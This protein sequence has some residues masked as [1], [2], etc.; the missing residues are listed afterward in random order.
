MQYFNAI[1]LFTIISSITLL[2]ITACQSSSSSSA[3]Y[4]PS[5]ITDGVDM[6]QY[7]IDKRNCLLEIQRSYANIESTNQIRFRECL[8]GKGYKLMS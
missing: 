8:I 7:E 3:T 2:L 6:K 5:I 1:S 4:N